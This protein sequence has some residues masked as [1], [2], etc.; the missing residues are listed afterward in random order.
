M[1]DHEADTI[2]N[3]NAITKHM[4]NIKLSNLHNDLNK[5]NGNCKSFGTKLYWCQ[6][7]STHLN[8]S[9]K[10]RIKH[11]FTLRNSAGKNAMFFAQRVKAIKSIEFLIKS[12]VV[13]AVDISFMTLPADG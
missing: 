10:Q 12:T 2:K 13:S 6:W 7:I 8:H 9:V 5:I 11:D 4:I 1:R 3:N